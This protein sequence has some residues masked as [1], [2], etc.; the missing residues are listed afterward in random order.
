MSRASDITEQRI[1]ALPTRLAQLRMQHGLTIRQC[2]AETGVPSTSMWK[3]YEDGEFKPWSLR[4]RA[5]IAAFFGVE[6]EELFG[7]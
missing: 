5:R 4:R 1:A 6:P 2:C 7:S 3:G